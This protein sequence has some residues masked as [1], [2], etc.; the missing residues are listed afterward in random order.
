MTI[1]TKHLR[2]AQPLSPKRLTRLQAQ[3][4]ADIDY[5]DI[6]A[7]PDEFWAN[8]AV[9]QVKASKIAVA[10]RLEPEVLAWFKAQGEGYTSR[11]AAV[12]RHFYDHH[13]HTSKQD[14]SL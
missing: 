11:M 1:V 12:L 7:L 2:E 8:A 3:S 6:P 10:L 13:S 4:D 9:Y 14:E 5:S